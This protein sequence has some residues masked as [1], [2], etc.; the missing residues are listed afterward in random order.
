MDALS[1]MLRSEGL[2]AQEDSA[3]ELDELH[4]TKEEAEDPFAGLFTQGGK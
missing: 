1:S 3:P 2:T 4:D